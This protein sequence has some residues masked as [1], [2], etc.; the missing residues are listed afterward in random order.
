MFDSESD[1]DTAFTDLFRSCK[2]NPGNLANVIKGVKS[3]Q[4]P[5][6]ETESTHRIEEKAYS[7]LGDSFILTEQLYHHAREFLNE[8]SEGPLTE[9]EF[10]TLAFSRLP[11][12]LAELA[13]E[14]WVDFIPICPNSDV[15]DYKDE[16]TQLIVRRTMHI[17]VILCY[18][19]TY[20]KPRRKDLYQRV[21]R[22][23]PK[24][25]TK[26]WQEIKRNDS[27]SYVFVDKYVIAGIFQ[28]DLDEFARVFDN[29]CG[30]HQNLLELAEEHAVERDDGIIQELPGHLP[31]I[32]MYLWIYCEHPHWPLILLCTVDGLQFPR[33]QAVFEEIDSEVF[34]MRAIERFTTDFREVPEGL[35]PTDESLHQFRSL[36]LKL[37]MVCASSYHPPFVKKAW[38]NIGNLMRSI[39]IGCQE[40]FCLSHLHYPDGPHQA[41]GLVSQAMSGF[42]AVARWKTVDTESLARKFVSQPETVVVAGQAMVYAVRE[43]LSENCIQQLGEMLFQFVKG[44]RVLISKP[45]KRNEECCEYFIKHMEVSWIF[46]NEQLEALSPRNLDLLR[47]RRFAIAS[48]KKFRTDLTETMSRE[49]HENPD[50]ATYYREVSLGYHCHYKACLCNRIRAAH[51][52][53]VCKGCWT[54]H[55]CC[56]ECQKRDWINHRANCGGERHRYSP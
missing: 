6:A 29:L 28:D 11:L 36:T 12:V 45:S 41:Q 17:V 49:L 32:L 56:S 38:E 27:F 51:S 3:W 13:T 20:L 50:I 21:Q 42:G 14:S 40:G 18:F 26:F 44:L 5:L 39:T 54:V 48:W 46:I 53:R 2:E 52:M 19:M 24:I 47:R 1:I 4:P 35:F 23:L 37:F 31:H 43:Q 30:I 16:R 34:A 25:W 33:L 55:Y 9:D 22:W 10:E 7:Y 15:P 8:N